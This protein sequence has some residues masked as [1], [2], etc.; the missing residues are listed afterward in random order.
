MCGKYR[1]VSTDM[2]LLVKIRRRGR[3][4]P[5]KTLQEVAWPATDALDRIC[6]LNKK[7][8]Y[9]VATSAK[10][11][12]ETSIKAIDRLREL[13]L[14]MDEAA[15]ERAA[16]M[17]VL[18]LNFNLDRSEWW[19]WVLHQGP[20][21]VRAIEFDPLLTLHDPVPLLREILVEACVIVRSHP[22]AARLVF[23]MSESVVA[24]FGKL[25]AS[26]IDS[27]ALNHHVELQLRWADN[28]TYWK[29]LLTAAVEGPFEELSAVRV[30]TLQLLG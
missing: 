10:S 2:E 28:L 26:E 6:H 3:R 29:H 11:N 22:R 12:Q 7:S 27:I 17:P 23:A 19:H 15:C 24:T 1:P 4:M 30:H 25:S 21:P 14:S 20:R 9:A 5:T 18:L 8:L 13:W 16:H